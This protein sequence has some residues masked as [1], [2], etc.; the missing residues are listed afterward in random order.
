MAVTP[1]RN[2]VLFLPVMR[3]NYDPALTRNLCPLVRAAAIR[4]GIDGIFPTADVGNEGVV[5]SD[6]HLRDYWLQWREQL[7]DVAALMV[8]SGDFMQERRIMDTVRLLPPD[9]PV[10]LIVN[11][12]DP[13]HMDGNA[14]GDSLCGSLS[15]YHNVRMLG[16]RIL[17]GARIR[18]ADATVLDG[19]LTDYVRLIDGN[20]ALRNMRV[21]LLGVNPDAFATTFVNQ[22]LL[23]KLGFSLHT[24]ELLDFWG[25]V[26]LGRQLAGSEQTCSGSF[27]DV[28]LLH[29][30]RGDDPRLPETLALIAKIMPARSGHTPE[31]LD[32]LARGFLWIK[33]LFE[34]DRIDA[35]GI[36][37]WG[38]F[39]R[40]FGI[41]ACALSMLANAVLDTP[42]VCEVDICHAIMNRLGNV[43]TGEPAVILDINNN[44]WDPRIFNVFHC[45]QTPPNWL[46]GGGTLTSDGAVQGSVRTVPFTAVS[47]A[48][49]ADAFN[50]TVY[51]GH[52]IPGDGGERGT[53]G[54][55]FVPNLPEVL[56]HLEETGIHHFVAMKGNVAQAVSD[57]L[58]FRGIPAV[59]MALPVP[60]LPE[61]VAGLPPLS[62]SSVQSCRIYSR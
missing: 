2:K 3:G 52:F 58:Q 33:D 36:H 30:V 7:Y 8:F 29:P 18:M 55:A 34:R 62:E 25:D 56:K 17:R 26:I 6:A 23:F 53:T 42:V 61:L 11:N 10:F 49:T 35:G 31:M 15:A 45:S 4:C 5:Q 50:A 22:P 47:A 14:V 9:T 39:E 13:C 21:A 20:E 27:A 43:L 54:W 1:R 32:R 38:E 16:R 48:T 46:Q 28:R 19:I 40:Y 51:T 44:G 59:N 37:C 57:L 24:Y 41:K 12:D 60:P